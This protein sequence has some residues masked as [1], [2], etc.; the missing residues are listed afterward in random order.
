MNILPF[1][2]RYRLEVIEGI[3]AITG[4]PVWLLEHASGEGRLCVSVRSSQA[5]IEDDSSHGRTI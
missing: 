4:Q 5:E 2:Y 1:P 3:D